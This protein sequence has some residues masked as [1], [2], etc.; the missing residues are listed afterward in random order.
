MTTD[1]GLIDGEDFGPGAR[2]CS[3]AEEVVAPAGQA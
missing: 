3:R 1:T 2:G